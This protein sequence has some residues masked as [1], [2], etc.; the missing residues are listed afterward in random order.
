MSRVNTAVQPQEAHSTYL[1]GVSQSAQQKHTA[2]G[3]RTQR[4]HHLRTSFSHSTQATCHPKSD[5]QASLDDR[6]LILESSKSP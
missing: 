3:T 2:P 6:A 4:G 5:R 1:A